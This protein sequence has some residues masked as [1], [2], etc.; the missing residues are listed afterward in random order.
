MAHPNAGQTA[1]P[2]GKYVASTATR[3]EL[4]PRQVIAF[5][6]AA[7]S[8]IDATKTPVAIS[9]LVY[10]TL[11]LTIGGLTPFTWSRFLVPWL[12]NYE[13]WALFLDADTFARGD[14]NDLFALANDECAVMVSDAATGNLAF[15]RAAVMLFNCAH[16]DNK[17]LTPELV[18]AQKD[19]GKRIGL[20]A[21]KWT[22]NVGT[23]PGGW[24]HLVH[25]MPPDP[26]A[27]LVHFTQ[28]VPCWPETKDSE[29]AAEWQQ[30]AQKAFTAQPWETL[31]GNS[32]HARPVMER[33]AAQKASNGAKP[34][35][36][37]NAA[38]PGVA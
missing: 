38:V 36:A 9:P 18:N 26:D 25:Y 35:N 22:Q 29:H 13:G 15:E 32:V 37:Q 6:V 10:Q 21:C 31:M 33:M 24:N 27:P 17:I 5:T 3:A 34:A 4:D 2:R 12:C 1:S 19:E 20:H 30:T 8:I 14:I 28:G 23:F 7:C 16:P 11:P